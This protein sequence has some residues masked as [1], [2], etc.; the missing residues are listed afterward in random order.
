[1]AKKTRYTTPYA[2]IFT[3]D[4]DV[5]STTVQL[6]SSLGSSNYVIPSP[7]R[8]EIAP[9]LLRQAFLDYN[10]DFSRTGFAFS[11][12]FVTNTQFVQ[13][14]YTI[15]YD[16]FGSTTLTFANDADAR[17]FGFADDTPI[18]FGPFVVKPKNDYNFAGVYAPLVK[19][20]N[21]A[22]GEDSRSTIAVTDGLTYDAPNVIKWG[23]DV[24]YIGYT[25]AYVQAANIFD[26]Y[27]ATESFATP[28]GRN[29][30][31]VYNTFQK[32]IEALRRNNGRTD[33][34]DAGTITANRFDIELRERLCVYERL[35]SLQ[36]RLGDM[37][38]GRLWDVDISGRV[39]LS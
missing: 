36:E 19:T 8:L 35:Q 4:S 24:R 22:A 30:L 20:F 13:V 34:Y 26:A 31:D 12:D 2:P 17:K 23:A 21:P 15:Q 37:S 27:A 6:S 32:F 16:P 11:Y 38:A 25:F 28:A 39:L 29:I 33:I 18:N 10:I 7:S 1:M 3:Y 5:G 9:E 14:E